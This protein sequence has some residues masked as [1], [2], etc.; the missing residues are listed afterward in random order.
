MWYAAIE[1]VNTWK[2][3]LAEIRKC[4]AQATPAEQWGVSETASRFLQGLLDLRTSESPNRWIVELNKDACEEM[5]IDPK[6]LN[7]HLDVRLAILAE[8]IS[9]MT[10]YLVTSY[11]LG[12]DHWRGGRVCL[13]CRVVKP[14][15]L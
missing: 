7:S 12:Q 2:E 1:P 9:E 5:G 15:A 13:H 6:W 11:S 14:G 4:H 10:P 8:E 3:T